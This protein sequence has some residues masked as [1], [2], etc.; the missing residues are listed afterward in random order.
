[1]LSLEKLLKGFELS[2]RIGSLD[3]R[4]FLKLV[5]GSGV[6]AELLLAEEAEAQSSLVVWSSGQWQDLFGIRSGKRT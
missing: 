5:A 2:D 4:D 3:R 6:T 1:M